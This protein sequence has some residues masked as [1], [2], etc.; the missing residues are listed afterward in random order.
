MQ[1]IS[2]TPFGQR[3][4]SAG[5]LATQALA[6]KA[7]ALPSIDK[8]SV[9]DDL[10]DARMYFGLSDRDLAVLAALLSFL[11]SRQVS[12]DV[13][14]LVY[15]SNRVLSERAHGMAESTLRR[16]LAHLVNAGV[17]LRHDSPNGKRYAARNYQ[18]EVVRAFGFDLRPLLVRAA[19]IAHKAGEAR[20]MAFAHKRLREDVVLRLRDAC[21][22]IEYGID[23]E[24]DKDWEDL[25][26]LSTGLR[27]SL[28]RVLDIAVLETMLSETVS[29]LR[30]IHVLLRQ[31]NTIEMSGSDVQ[32]ERH[33]QN[34]NK[35]HSDLES[36]AEGRASVERPAPNTG[37]D[38]VAPT[39]PNLPLGLVLK[40]CPDILPYAKDEIHH[41]HQ[42]IATASTVRGMMGI[43]PHAWQQAQDTMGPAVAAI[44]CAAILQRVSDIRSP[45]GYLR[46]L[47]LRCETQ[48]FSPGPMIMALLNGG[49]AQAA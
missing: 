41:W 20:E 27:K 19:E 43:S 1:H 38:Y 36:C 48:G 5:L 17:I 39:E 8:Y 3:A 4:V 16:H 49:T 31:S 2:T 26:L 35:E 22:L 14:T 7:P 18:G 46:A 30:V 9:L 44:T 10:R 6:Q 28:R 29:M 15:P 47:T 25:I 13:A 42:L 40:A 34:S 21:K 37:E 24:P 33:Y 11:P 32:N 45:G 23:T 12:Q